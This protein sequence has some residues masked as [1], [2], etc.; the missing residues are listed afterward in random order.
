MNVQEKIEKLIDQFIEQRFKMDANEFRRVYCASD[1]LQ[2]IY[3][4]Q[5]LLMLDPEILPEFRGSDEDP[6]DIINAIYT[7]VEED[8]NATK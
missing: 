4:V 1:T 2:L 7:R 5:K 6:L 3:K 8:Y